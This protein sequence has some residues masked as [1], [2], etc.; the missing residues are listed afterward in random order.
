MEKK[1]HENGH[2]TRDAMLVIVQDSMKEMA[3]IVKDEIKN[4]LASRPDLLKDSPREEVPTE[5][6]GD[7]LGRTDMMYTEYW[8]YNSGGKDKS[9]VPKNTRFLLR[10]HWK[11]DGN[12]VLWTTKS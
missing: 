7:M 8:L 10:S 3:V 4:S 12:Y 5:V 2:L 6:F 9:F 1:A 11:L